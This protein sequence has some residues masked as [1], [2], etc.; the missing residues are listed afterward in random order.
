MFGAKKIMQKVLCLS[1]RLENKK[2]FYIGLAI[3]CD[4]VHIAVCTLVLSSL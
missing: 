1:P 2:Q 4:P 3:F